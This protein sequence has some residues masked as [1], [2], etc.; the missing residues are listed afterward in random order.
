MDKN[1][2]TFEPGEFTFYLLQYPDN[3][4]ED[5]KIAYSEIRVEVRGINSHPPPDLP[6]DV[7]YFD[8]CFAFKVYTPGY[9]HRQFSER[10]EFFFFDRSVI[11]VKEFD[12][13][14]IRKAI[15]TLLPNI[16]YYGEFKDI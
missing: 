14:L 2:E 3:L 9:I 10:G 4:P 5:P 1:F 15:E 13:E 16:T 12:L 8:Y 6:T 11:I 7:D